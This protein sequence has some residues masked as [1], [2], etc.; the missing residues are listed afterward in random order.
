[1]VDK[2]E[3]KKLDSDHDKK[4]SFADQQGGKPPSGLAREA[5]KPIPERASGESGRKDQVEEN[6]RVPGDDEAPKVRKFSGD[7]RRPGSPDLNS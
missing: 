2:K 7:V 1:M 4:V 6:P 5:I 3:D